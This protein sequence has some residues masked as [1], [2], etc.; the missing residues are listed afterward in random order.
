[1]HGVDQ[2]WP[3]PEPVEADLVSLYD[4]PADL[5]EPFVRVNFVSSVDGAVT[6]NGRSGGLS[7]PADKYLFQL[8][9]ALSD[10]IVVGAGT[11]RAEGYRGARISAKHAEVRRRL[12]LS[13]VPPIAV[14]TAS[15]W[16][17]SEHI[18]VRDA[19]VPPIVITVESAPGEH[20]QALADAGVRVLIAGSDRVDVS[21]AVRVLGELGLRRVLAEGGPQLFG[22]LIV[23]GLVDEL[24]L[25]LSPRLVLGPAGRIA[26]GLTELHDRPLRLTSAVHS[27]NELMLRYRRAELA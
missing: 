5:R 21:A 20:R 9:R 26:S 13:A 23:A 15:C 2:L 7:D 18:L 4:Y 8:L 19:A 27:D 10:V 11:A 6:V 17:T 25:T 12:G 24:C 22:D 14:V 16:L 1:M 3:A